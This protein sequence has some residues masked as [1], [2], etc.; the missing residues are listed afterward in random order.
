M[1]KILLLAVGLIGVASVW[2]VVATAKNEVVLQEPSPLETAHPEVADNLDSMTP[3][4][5]NAFNQAVSEIGPSNTQMADV[6]PNDNSLLARGQ[7]RARA[8]GVAGTAQLIKHDNQ[9][10][11]RFEDFNT[12]NGPSLK[13]YLSSN[14]GIA[15]A[16]DLGPIR[17]TMGDVNYSVSPDVDTQKYNKVLV[18]CEPFGVLF[19]FAELTAT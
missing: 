5:R 17:A 12:I 16:I 2:Y 15:D 8:H 9:L 14:L 4:Q 1:K 19:S 7:F 11:L 18:W 3:D 6:M 10:T 13:I